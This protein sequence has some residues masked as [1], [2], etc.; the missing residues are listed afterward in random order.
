MTR[1]QDQCG[2]TVCLKGRILGRAVC[3]D[4]IVLLLLVRLRR[5]RCLSVEQ[6]PRCS[7]LPAEV[8][9]AAELSW[10]EGASL[11]PASPSGSFPQ[12][13]PALPSCVLG[14]ETL[15]IMDSEFSSSCSKVGCPG[16][17]KESLEG[18]G[19]TQGETCAHTHLEAGKTESH[20]CS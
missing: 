3:R 2:H 17:S 9:A 16:P 5:S 11:A 10:A 13:Q 14:E 4:G 19:H 1:M 12:Q 20:C 7:L 18:S 15:S 6:R 8:A